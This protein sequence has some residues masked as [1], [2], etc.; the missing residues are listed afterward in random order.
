MAHGKRSLVVATKALCLSLALLSSRVAW[1]QVCPF[2]GRSGP[3][4]PPSGIPLCPTI[5]SPGH[6]PAAADCCQFV[7]YSCTAS[8]VSPAAVDKHRNLLLVVVDDLGHCSN[9]VMSGRCVQAGKRCTDGSTCG[10]TDCVNGYCR[11]CDAFTPCTGGMLCVDGLCSPSAE[12]PYGD[13]QCAQ[14]IGTCLAGA[15]TATGGPCTRDTDCNDRCVSSACGLT[16]KPC[17]ANVDC[18]GSGQVCS[19]SSAPLRLNDLSCRN[20]APANTASNRIWNYGRTSLPTIPQA[21]LYT[22]GLDAIARQGAI[23]PRARNGA[24][25]CKP[26]RGVLFMGRNPR[27][28]DFI[29]TNGGSYARQCNFN[30]SGCPTVCAVGSPCYSSDVC[31]QLH[32]NAWWMRHP[33]VSSDT[34][35]G[36]VTISAGKVEIG[37]VHDVLSFDVG[38]DNGPGPLIGK[39][40]CDLGSDCAVAL[41]NGRIPEAATLA[42]D[43]N[44]ISPVIEEVRHL[45]AV[46]TDNTQQPPLTTSELQH[47]FFVWYAPH[48]PHEGIGAPPYFQQLYGTPGSLDEARDQLA[49]I[50]WLDVGVNALVD[51]L[52]R[53]CICGRDDSGNPVKQSVY[54]TT[55][56]IILP[57]NAFGLPDAKNSADAAENAH[58]E[59]LYLN[60]PGHR[61]ASSPI[62]PRV[63]DD[64]TWFVGA[65][66]VLPTLID[67]GGIDSTELNLSSPSAYPL[68]RSL[69]PT[70]QNPTA[71]PFRRVHYGA[72]GGQFEAQ[73]G[74]SDRAYMVPRPGGAYMGL[75]KQNNG[76]PVLTANSQVRPCHVD[77]DCTGTGCA[78]TPCTCQ[79]GAKRCVNRPDLLCTDDA[80]CAAGLCSGGS[81]TGSTTQSGRYF[82]FINKSCGASN[83][84]DLA[85]VPQGVCRQPM[86]K[87]YSSGTDRKVRFAY[88]ANAD[89]DQGVN[90]I[91]TAQDPNYFGAG[92]S[93]TIC[94]FPYA[95][96]TLRQT[97]ECCLREFYE[98]DPTSKA[99]G[100]PSYG[101]PTELRSWAP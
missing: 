84:G 12:C 87:I 29:G 48:V 71:T 76:N 89:P 16:P 21:Q 6:Y 13:F 2:D 96:A 56:V 78:S 91:A 85:C 20:R 43:N 83:G 46:G 74:N 40:D 55:V 58:R 36:Y 80:Q 37:D 45:I 19:T 11:Q 60:E 77:G 41:T 44:S 49:R 18:T 4:S 30:M 92:Y 86:F 88:D 26:G 1:S 42:G 101:C 8:T 39:F 9:G 81:C 59:L 54:D 98:I 5:G 63:F 68:N 82:D 93:G 51:E 52:K 7:D 50:A 99:W 72:D 70:V 23:F 65:V 35:P 3:V 47:P 57:D 38:I 31:D 34:T 53:T 28:R 14:G 73:T 33:Y 69:K 22:P 62:P 10:G 15:C 17:R 66:D 61:R 27:H 67:Y 100:R 24:Q 97:F 64:N 79:I 25:S 94:P 90:L 32:V 95:P 75:C